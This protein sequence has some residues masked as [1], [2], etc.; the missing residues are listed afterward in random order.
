[1]YR[2][3]M[4]QQTS[5]ATNGFLYNIIIVYLN[6]SYYNKKVVKKRQANKNTTKKTKTQE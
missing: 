1:M 2:R 5:D 6:Q 3:R 4:L